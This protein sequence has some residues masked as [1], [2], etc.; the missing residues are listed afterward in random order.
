MGAKTAG[1]PEYGMA[2]GVE[3]TTG[4]LGQGLANAVGFAMAERIQQARFGDELVDH[5]T[6]VIAG[7]GCLMEGL[8]QEAISLAGHLRLNK[9]I[10]LFDDN[11][12]S[13][14]GPTSLSTSEDHVGRFKAAGWDVQE[15]DGHDEK[16]IHH[17]IFVAR[18]TKTPSL[19]ACKTTIAYGAPTKKGTSASHGSPLGKEE[20]AG[21][22]KQLGWKYDAFEIPADILNAWRSVGRKG[23]PEREVWQKT[24]NLSVEKAEFSRLQSGALPQSFGS[25]VQDL[26]KRL[27]EERPGWA[28]RK[29]SG[30]VLEV[31]SQAIPE[32]MGGSADLT[33]S[34]LTKAKA[35]SPITRE[36]FSG[37]YIYYGIREHAMAAAM[38][39]MALHGGVIPYG[40]TF[41]VFTDYCRPSIRLAALMQ[42]RVVFVMTHDSIG[43]G[44]DGPTHQPIEHMASLR[45]I[46]NLNV[47]RPADAVET[48]ECWELALLSDKAPS[49]LALT[50]QG[51]P[52]LR[53]VHE[54]KNRCAM[55]AYILAEAEGVLNVTL[56]A[57]GSEVS[58]AM[59]VREALQKVGQ[60]VRVISMP[61]TTLFDKQDKD[62]KMSLLCNDSLKVSIEAAST[63][64]WDRYTGIHGLRIGIDSF[65]ESAPAEELY[66][67]FGLTVESICSRI[68]QKLES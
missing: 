58:L 52:A 30:E 23:S 37:R 21:A 20:I 16:A 60:G 4:P 54:Q 14:D 57:T 5:Y 39:G 68:K 36:D 56:L 40:G 63:Y 46:P 22:K 12:I 42:Q 38:N 55:G 6:Y 31:F 3:T 25:V 50:R 34:N 15:I 43:L 1:H 65:G 13:I 67:H 41:L 18:R 44:E 51:V 62:Y 47:F 7:D 35:Q 8:S 59:Q 2:A 53:L 9:L 32:L 27:V 33:G 10:V 61:S 28:T 66:A 19:I 45:A 64:G 24:L 49:V 48:L 17:A 11:G 26:K 29:A